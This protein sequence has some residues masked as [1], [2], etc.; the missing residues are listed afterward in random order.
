MVIRVTNPKW[1]ETAEDHKFA[2]DVLQL[3]LRRSIL[4]FIGIKTRSKRD[5]EK[6]FGLSSFMTEFHLSMLEKALVVESF[7]GE[8]K[9]TSTGICYLEKVDAKC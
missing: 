3:G 1:W 4:R 2:L 6:N 9:I 8:F 5:I 7:E